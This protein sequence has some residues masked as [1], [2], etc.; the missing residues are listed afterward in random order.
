MSQ[1]RDYYPLKDM[2]FSCDAW[3]NGSPPA[4]GLPSAKFFRNA[5]PLGDLHS[6]FGR[7]DE[8]ARSNTAWA[9]EVSSEEVLVAG[10]MQ[11]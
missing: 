7:C 8:H 11:R 3:P 1:Y 9:V 4:C 10:L 5:T 6:Y 2:I